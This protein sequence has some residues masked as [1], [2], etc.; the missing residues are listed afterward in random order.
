MSGWFGTDLIFLFLAAL[1]IGSFLGVLVERLPTGRPVVLD[2]SACPHCGQR[3][4]LRDLVPLFSWVANQGRCRACGQ[5]LSLFYPAIEILAVLVAFWALAVVPGWT[6]WVTCV[7]GWV[8]LTLAIIDW[9]HLLLPDSLTLPLIAGGLPVAW[10]LNPESLL[11][12][13]IGAVAGFLLLVIVGAVYGW[14][15]GRE[16]I[17]LG[18]A[19]LLASAGAW[20][21]WQ[22]LPSVVLIAAATGLAGALF[23][24][25]LA[26][27]LD[28]KHPVP[29]GSYL[30]GGFWLVWLYGP[31][32]IG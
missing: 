9:R 30:A 1:C 8:L 18:D 7:L 16:G 25:R 32:G 11:D 5:R 26:G 2:R 12:H 4:G 29:F 31:L 23:Q 28:A 3:L 15:R 22:G 27:Q 13:G 20:L 19:K 10:Y 17:G 6:V 24:A 14:L 21:G